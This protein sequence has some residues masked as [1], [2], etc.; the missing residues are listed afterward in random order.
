MGVAVS[1][2]GGTLSEDD[3][4]KLT[5]NYSTFLD[6]LVGV[7]GVNVGNT[8]NIKKFI[9]ERKFLTFI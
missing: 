3:I 4:V 5:K 7:D 8:E 2:A 9:E 6:A 1:G